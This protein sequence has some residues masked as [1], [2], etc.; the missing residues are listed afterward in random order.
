MDSEFIFSWAE[1]ENGKMVHVDSVPKG[2]ACKCKCP[3]CHEPLVARHGEVKKHGFAHHSENRQSN[4]SICYQVTLYKLAEYILQTKKRLRLPSYYG[5]FKTSDVEF[6][7]VKIDNHYEREDKQPDVIATTKDG[8]KYLIEFTFEQKVKHIENWDYQN[9]TCL[10]I[11][12]SGQDLNT[13]ERFL[14]TSDENRRWVNNNIYFNKIES[15]YHEKGIQVKVVDESVCELCEVKNYCCA[16]KLSSITE[17]P[18]LISN[19]GKTYRICKTEEYENLMREQDIEEQLR[20]EEGQ[21]RIESKEFIE[22]T[23]FNALTS[24]YIKPDVRQSLFLSQ[25]LTEKD[26]DCKQE[27][28]CYNCEKNLTWGNRNGKAKCGIDYI[29]GLQNPDRAKTCRLFVKKQ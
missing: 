10:E 25:S 14:I 28:S 18:I 29:K 22:E 4:L 6:V 21:K 9:L 15:F 2:L 5:I 7:D 13:L 19:N 20:K 24:T 17:I 11:D 8:L 26:D 3:H 23:S 27:R 16:V 12:L 1:N